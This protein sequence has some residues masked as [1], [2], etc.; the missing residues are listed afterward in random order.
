M[1]TENRYVD[2]LY[3]VFDLP[4][5]AGVDDATPQGKTKPT[6][7][8]MFYDRSRNRRTFQ[9]L[10]NRLSDKERKRIECWLHENSQICD[11][12][13]GIDLSGA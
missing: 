7:V 13:N 10:N 3:S 6:C 8:M 12:L 2:R 11:T 5:H 4:E 9:V 1:M